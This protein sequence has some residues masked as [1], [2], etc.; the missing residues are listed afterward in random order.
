MGSFAWFQ[1]GVGY[2]GT[3][4]ANWQSLL[5]PRGSLKHLFSD[6]SGFAATSN[7]GN[8]T[9]SVASG[10]VL[11]GGVSSGGTWAWSDAAT[12]AVPTA[13]NDNPRKDLIVARLTTAAVDGINGLAVELIPGTP[14]VSPVAPARPDNAVALSIVDVP[15]ASTTFTT[16]P[17]RYTGQYADQATFANGHVAISWATLPTATAFPVGFTLYNI[18]TNQRWVRRNDGTWYT[19]DPGPWLSATF[20]PYVGLGSVTTTPSGNLYIRESSACW[21]LSGQVNLTPSNGNP[22]GLKVIGQMPAGITRPAVNVYATVAQTYNATYGGW[23][24]FGLMA[25]GSIEWGAPATGAV[26]TIYLSATYPKNPLNAP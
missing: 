23:A 6:T 26:G 16:T 4:L 9:V 13:S 5:L 14:A 19:T 12:I 10:N 1:D 25:N 15:K 17:V 24:R 3:D 20:Q 7:L 22:N 11:I 21:E 18:T 2:G 8:R